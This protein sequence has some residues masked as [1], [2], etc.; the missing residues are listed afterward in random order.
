MATPALEIHAHRVRSRLGYPFDPQSLRWVLSRDISLGLSWMPKLLT[1]RLQTSAMRVFQ[2]YAENYSPGYANQASEGLHRFARFCTLGGRKLAAITADNLISYRATLAAHQEWR[3]GSFST[4]VRRWHALGYTGVDPEVPQLLKGWRLRGSV[5]GL[6]VQT[7]CPY[8]GPLSELEFAALRQRIIDAYEARSIKL[9]DLVLVQLFMATGRR[10][11]QL[12][13][14]KAEDLIASS[15]DDGTQSFLLNVPR[16]KQRASGWRQEFKRFALRP[17]LGAA[18]VQLI[19]SN[20]KKFNGRRRVPIEGLGSLP[21]FPLWSKIE[22]RRAQRLGLPGLSEVADVLHQSTQQM[23]QWLTGVIS[24]LKIC[25]ERTGKHLYV[26]PLRLRRT[27]ATRA[28][29]E[30]H[31]ELIIAELLDH[32]DTQ[33][34]K[35]YT[36]NVPEHVDAINEAVARQLAP[37]AQAFSGVLVNSEQSAR[38]GED[39][40]SRIRST[41]GGVGT[42]GHF[43]FCGGAAPI[44]CYTCTN[45]QPWLHGPHREVLEGLLSE[46]DR[47]AALTQDNQIASINDRTILAVTQVV[48]LCETRQKPQVKQLADG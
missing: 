20:E 23:Q 30:G 24:S 17:E 22:R 39:P 48:Q 3:L 14:L 37:L 42:C 38:R 6:A 40:S 46:R 15:E 10:P 31:G 2:F 33:N 9:D 21:L 8:E 29:R 7:K 18:I 35:V 26:F 45:F 13:S 44:A 34:A 1:T 11:T 43:G 36:E 12:A 27:I 19:A 4:I 32:T 28:A 41:S 5:K 16:S 25:S 47:I